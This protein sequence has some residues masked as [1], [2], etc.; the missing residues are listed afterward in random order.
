MK[1]EAILDR[2]IVVVGENG[3]ANFGALQNWRCEADGDLSYYV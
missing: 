3:L 1:P 2:E